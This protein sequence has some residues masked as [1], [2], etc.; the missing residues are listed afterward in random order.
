[1]NSGLVSQPP[2]DRT[3]P[4]A[5]RFFFKKGSAKVFAHA[6][7]IDLEF[8]RAT[9]GTGHKDFEYYRLLEETVHSGF[10][11]RYLVLFG[12]DERAIALQ[13]LIVVDQDL[14]AAINGRIGRAIKTIRAR[15][16]RF[17]Y[18]R[19]VM[20]GCVVGDGRLG[21]LANADPHVAIE[22]LTEALRQF[23]RT[24]AISLVTF[25]DFSV[26]S[27]DHLR[28]LTRAGYTR[29]D[30]F[31]S[32]RL[33]LTFASVNEYMQQRLTRVTR[34]GFKRKLRKTARATPPIELEVLE[35]SSAISDEVYQLYLNVAARS[36]VSFEVFSKR[37][38][39]EAALH[40]PGH[41]RYFIWR[42]DGKPIAFSF[43]TVWGHT[44]YDHDIGLDYSVAHELNLYHVTFRDILDWA[45]KN[46]LR[47][48]ETAPFNYGVKL[49]LRLEPVPLDV[50]VRHTSPLVN[51]GLRF[52]APF[53]AP[54]KSDPALRR[55]FRAQ[56]SA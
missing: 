44:I 16:P 1:M 28:P 15:A 27:R 29:L 9:F 25:K 4:G 33:D 45:L 32:L 23:A 6:I 36:E 24:E 11:Y 41:V 49:H 34:K 37:Y 7:D 20:A 3:L 35:D 50:Y 13:P 54:A 43:C 30:G 17:L 18:S 31:P 51:F 5:L 56:N 46:G 10:V 2:L 14:A 48:Y 12:L 40:M 42:T 22:L 39:I 52:I 21:L 8:W 53:F 19:M 26:H 55:Y 38:F 47:V